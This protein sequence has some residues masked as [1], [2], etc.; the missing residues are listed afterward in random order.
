MRAV[1]GRLF[2]VLLSLAVSLGLAEGAFVFLLGHSRVAAGLPGGVLSHLR[3][4]YLHHD[5]VMVQAMPECSRYDPGLFYTLKPGE[6]RF[7]N[8]EF[9]TTLRVKPQPGQSKPKSRRDKQI[10]GKGA[11]AMVTDSFGTWSAVATTNTTRAKSS[12]AK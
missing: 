4:F 9:D 7:A 8:R 3:A 6:C 12:Q 11:P 2:L 1:L 10:S 5:R